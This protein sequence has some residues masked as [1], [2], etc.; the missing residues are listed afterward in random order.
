MQL[1]EFL[2]AAS[3]KISYKIKKAA[4]EGVLPLVRPKGFEP[5][6]PGVGGQ[7][8]IQLSYGRISMKTAD[9]DGFQLL[10]VVV[11]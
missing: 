4:P 8:S 5:P 1:F 7:C 9:A 11:K 3:R 2:L 10:G 6:A